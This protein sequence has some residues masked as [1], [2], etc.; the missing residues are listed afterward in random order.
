MGFVKGVFDP[1]YFINAMASVAYMQMRNL[2]VRMK[3]EFGLTSIGDNKVSVTKMDDHF[4]G[5]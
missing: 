3:H 5:K 4:V 2:P 1:D